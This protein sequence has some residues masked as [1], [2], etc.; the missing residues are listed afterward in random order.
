MNQLYLSGSTVYNT[1]EKPVSAPIFRRIFTYSGSVQ[2]LRLSISVVGFYRLFLNGIEITKGMLAPYISNPSEIVYEDRYEISRYLKVGKN[3]LDV[4]LGNGFS[5]CNDFN[6][7]DFEKADFRSSPSFCLEIL[8]GN[9]II[10]QTDEQFQVCDSPILFDDLRCGEWYNAALENLKDKYNLLYSAK[11][12]RAPIIV[13]PPLGIRKECKAEPIHK[14]ERLSPVSV[15]RS[16]KGYIYDFGKNFSGVCALNIEG[17]AGVEVDLIYFEIMKNGRPYLENISFPDRSKEGFIQHDKYICRDGLQ[18]WRP[19]FTYHGYRYVYVEG[20]E[21]W[22][23]TKDLLTGEVLHSDIEKIGSFS[24]SD[25]MVN[26]IQKATLQSDLSNF[27]YFPTDCP[28]REKNG[29]TGDINLSAE[30]LLYNFQCDKSLAEWMDNVCAAQRENGALPGIVPTA[31]WG[32]SWGNGPAWDGVLI[33]VPYQLYRFTGNIG[34]LRNY[35]PYIKKYIDYLHGKTDREGLIS[36]GLGDWCEA[37]AFREDVFSTPVKVT[38]TLVS[39]DLLRKASEIFLILNDKETSERI[40]SFQKSL[41]RNFKDKC[42]IGNEVYCKTQTAQA[43][44][45]GLGL[46]DQN[47]QTAYQV[48]KQ[49]IADNGNKFKV[50]VIGVKWLFD[51]LSD[52]GD[53]DIAMELI[54]DKKFPSYAYN[55][56]HCET[57]LCEAFIE[58]DE[59]CFPDEY[60]RKDGN[61]RI[62]SFNH[63]FWGSISAWFYKKLAGID[64]QSANYVEIKPKYPVSIDY[65]SAG[66]KLNDN[67]IKIYWKKIKNKIELTV[68]NN[69][70]KGK[71]Y[72]DKME[73]L[74]IGTHQYKFSIGEDYE[75]I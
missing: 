5:N 21:D 61:S 71:V 73:E 4:L 6:V 47:T 24:C 44:A 25:E 72:T 57:S 15:I 19:S 36:F 68:I 38:D 40:L 48:L 33:E 12:V 52:H 30:Q 56:L 63:H 53:L 62:L 42:I 37:G 22:Q 14:F 46:F 45:I 31:G 41:C 65:V 64:I 55:I 9:T 35:A 43:M 29:W 1:T 51:V 34:Y 27:F 26:K 32:F 23:A 54:T 70:F 13:S 59:K 66:I 28:H 60:V 8:Q 7:W 11:N 74:S 3:V 58:F 75:K 17:K 67:Q 39:I 69:G 18:T 50:G 49:F 20:I 10:L 16:G 2:D